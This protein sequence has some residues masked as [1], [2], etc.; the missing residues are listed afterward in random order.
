MSDPQLQRATLLINQDKYDKARDILNAVLAENPEDVT[1]LSLMAVVF[2]E[3]NEYDKSLQTLD[4]ALGLQPDNADLFY[5]KALTLS[6]TGEIKKA[7]KWADEAIAREPDRSEFLS[8]RSLLAFRRK[9]FKET[10]EW[11]EKALVLDPENLL[12]LNMRSSALTKLNR[13]EES[14]ATIE[15]ALKEDP[16][17]AFTH[18]NF[19]WNLLEQ[20]DR[21]KALEHFREALKIDPTLE[22]AQSGM[23]EAIK[24]QYWF[25]RWYLKYQIWMSNKSSQVQ[26]AFILV[27][28]FGFK[29]LSRIAR[30]SPE[31]MPF[32]VPIMV[33]LG[34]FALSTWI[35]TPVSNLFLRL[36][37]YG[38]HL[39]DKQE[40]MA[41]NLVGVFAG[42]CI[43][44]LAGYVAGFGK[45]SVVLA[46]YGFGMMVPMDSVFA[47]TRIKYLLPVYV[48]AMGIVGLLGTVM[49]FMKMGVFNMFTVIFFLGFFAYQWIANFAI[50]SHGNR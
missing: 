38:R 50:I 18:A 44:G 20:G 40:I 2:R 34:V 48:S 4:R 26:W 6:Y 9:D 43:L 28:Y 46:G 13:K 49:A 42:V 11:A 24:A 41:S 10:L 32:I 19:G 3:T 21:K 12:A 8:V 39:L 29:M 27:I 37:T 36:N 22:F 16:N 15:G 7:H 30:T 14:A 33:L 31:A 17:N 35:M 47:E 45:A 25:Y 1:A 23:V 5:L